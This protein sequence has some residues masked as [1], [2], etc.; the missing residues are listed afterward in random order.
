MQTGRWIT[1]IDSL[2]DFL[3][4]M[5]IRMDLSTQMRY[6]KKTQNLFTGL[7]KLF[8]CLLIIFL[9]YFQVRHFAQK[10]KLLFMREDEVPGMWVLWDNKNFVHHQSIFYQSIFDSR[11]MDRQKVYGMKK[12]CATE[13]ERQLWLPANA[14]YSPFLLLPIV[15]LN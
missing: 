13:M 8:S 14:I 12:S 7:Y 10:R 9:F 1:R 15:W 4:G 5:S 6:I 3:F 11:K 2:G